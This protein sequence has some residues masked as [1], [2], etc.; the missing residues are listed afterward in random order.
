MSVLRRAG[1]SIV[2]AALALPACKPPPSD[3]AF[4][5]SALLTAASGPSAP[6]ASPDA[7]AAIWA[8][9]GAKTAAPMRLI[10]GVPGQA[11]LVS[12][13]CLNPKAPDAR[14]RITRYAPADK[15]AGA[16][17]ALIGNRMVARVEVDATTLGGRL[18]WQGE[19][20]ASL[21]TWDAFADPIDATVTVPGAGLVRLN[22]SP[23]PVELVTGCRG[24]ILPPEP[25]DRV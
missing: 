21:P 11:V 6:L 25:A 4:A 17:L 10:Y 1:P 18:V 22:P 15:G 3:A 16:L 24:A 7:T 8:P 13:E 14:L 12:L 20:S 2:L 19:A 5:R 9:S 23:L